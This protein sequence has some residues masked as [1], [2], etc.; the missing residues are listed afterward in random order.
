MQIRVSMFV[1][2]DPNLNDWPDGADELGCFHGVSLV[3][4]FAGLCLVASSPRTS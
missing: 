4:W 3:C 1:R 2:D